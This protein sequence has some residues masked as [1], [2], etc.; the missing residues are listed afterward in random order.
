MWSRELVEETTAA[1]LNEKFPNLYETK[2]SF[3]CSQTLFIR[4]NPQPD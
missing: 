2:I 4:H 3:Q 1:Q